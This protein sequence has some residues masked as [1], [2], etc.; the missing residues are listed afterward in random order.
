MSLQPHR[1][2]H[3]RCADQDRELVAQVLNNAYADGR[4]TFDEHADRIARAYD[5]RTFGDL[6][7]LTTDLVHQPRP[8]GQ[9]TPQPVTAPRTPALPTDFVGGNAIL[10]SL[11]PGAITRVAEEVTVNVWL[12]DA[13]IDLVGAAFASHVTT[14]YLGGMM[15]DV[16]IRVPEGV[17]V[18]FSGLT[19]IMGDTKV[20]G[21]VPHPSGI[22]INVTG[23]IVMAD[24]QVIGPRAKNPRKYERFTR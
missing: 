9:P 1:L 23:T 21:Q 6:S 17:E 24:I 13:K 11:K 7:P 14:L 3:L 5:A 22:V 12:S 10:S 16:K 4:L 18:N 8:A 19:T 20:D 15:A 2:D